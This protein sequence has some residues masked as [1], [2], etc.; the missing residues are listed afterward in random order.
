MAHQSIFQ[1]SSEKVVYPGMWLNINTVHFTVKCY[2]AS[3]TQA[4]AVIYLMI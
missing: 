3:I 4:K 1:S 2:A